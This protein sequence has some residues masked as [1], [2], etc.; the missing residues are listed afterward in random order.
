MDKATL[1][2]NYQELGNIPIFGMIHLTG[3]NPVPNALRELETYE[4]FGVDGAI[5]ENYFGSVEDVI[6]TLE[7]KD[8]SVFDLSIGVNILPNEF[9]KSFQ[10]ADRYGADF[11]QI[12]H[13]SGMYY[14]GKI[15]PGLYKSV[16][17]Q[18]PEIV[19]LGGVWPKYYHPVKSSN[20]EKDLMTAVKR[21]EAIVV[22]GEGTGKETPLDKIKKFRKTIGEHPLVIGAGLNLENAYGQL[23]YADGAIVGSYFKEKER[24]EN[25]LDRYKIKNFMSLVQEC[26]Q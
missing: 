19:V 18:Y 25:K 22:T 2:N 11:I 21:A 14:E 3:N 6:K 9:K 16:K 17:N 7:E 24:A 8:K 12:D 4:E 13:I 23:Q 10:L 15:N 1:N 20:L 26:R 5:I